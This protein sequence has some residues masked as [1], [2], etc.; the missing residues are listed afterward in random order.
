MYL[1]GESSSKTY[2]LKILVIPSLQLHV[3]EH[4]IKILLCFLFKD[5]NV[6]QEH[7]C[8]T[9]CDFFVFHTTLYNIKRMRMVIIKFYKKGY[10]LSKTTRVNFQNYLNYVTVLIR[11]IMGSW[12]KGNSWYNEE[13]S[14]HIKDLARKLNKM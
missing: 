4:I 5:F 6:I 9:E 13:F 3:R 10:I 14:C 1:H 12:D 11:I 2:T 7:Q 8:E